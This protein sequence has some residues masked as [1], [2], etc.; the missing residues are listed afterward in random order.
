VIACVLLGI[1]TFSKPLNVLAAAPVLALALWRRQGWRVLLICIA[2]VV[3]TGGLFVANLISSGDYNYQGGGADR[4]TFYGAFPFQSPDATFEKLGEVRAT[5]GL[6]T[7]VIFNRDALTTVLPWNVVYF[8]LGRHTGLVPYFFPAIVCVA[9]FLLA[10]RGTRAGFQ[11]LL[12]GTLVVAALA[13]LIYMPFTYSGGGGPVGNRYFLSYYPLFLFL[14]PAGL[15]ARPAVVALAV[16]SLFTGQLVFNPFYSSFRPETHAKYGL[17]R[18]LPIELSLMNDMPVNVT[19]SRVRQDLAGD[20]PLKVYFLDDNAYN[21]EG[22]WFWVRG[23]SR[24][25]LIL[26]APA[27]PLDGGGHTVLALDALDIEVANGAAPSVVTVDTGAEEVRVE[28]GAYNAQTVRVRMPQGFPYKSVPGQPMNR[29]YAVSIASSEGFIPMFD[30]GKRDSRFLGTRVRI[31]PV[32]RDD[33][34]VPPR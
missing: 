13:L 23:E 30:E 1:A 14:V 3:A 18:Y 34:Y 29:V 7:D 6:L 19:P 22:E 20:P 12:L 4:S 8:L 27:R 33:R 31:V 25:D 11:W 16:G 2:F 15:S 32:Y 9:L 28:P 17:Y 5:D 26:R 24:A 10:R 21:R